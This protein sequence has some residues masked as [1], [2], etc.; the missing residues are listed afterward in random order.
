MVSSQFGEDIF[1]S[2]RRYRSVRKI[3]TKYQIA[4]RWSYGVRLKTPSS[5]STENSSDSSKDRL[6]QELSIVD[7]AK[8]LLTGPGKPVNHSVKA[9]LFWIMATGLI[10]I[11]AILN[12][13]KFP[14]TVGC[15]CFN[16]TIDISYSELSVQMTPLT[17]LALSTSKIAA[18]TPGKQLEVL[19][20][21]SKWADRYIIMRQR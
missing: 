2:E 8:T 20:S 15:F 9:V 17:K 3:K 21:I 4:W 1:N 7:P 10:F 5:T 14:H 19:L 18:S 12:S 13:V 11:V 16:D 6:F